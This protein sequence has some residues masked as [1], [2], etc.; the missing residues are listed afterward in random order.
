[1]PS[2]L[3]PP[4]QGFARTKQ[5]PPDADLDI[6]ADPRG[7]RSKKPRRSGAV[8]TFILQVQPLCVSWRPKQPM[9]VA[10]WLRRLGPEQ[11]EPAFRENDID[12]DLLPSLT[13]VD[14]KD[15]G[16]TSVGHRRRL[17]DAIA[18]VGTESA[19][20]QPNRVTSDE[21]G[22]LSIARRRKR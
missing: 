2:Q 21:K 11:Y 4:C 12:S 7:V 10:E 17:L 6:A 22:A 18:A 13:A 3:S 5:V 19:H 8:G 14:L 20:T 9:N 16:I 15:L 1:M